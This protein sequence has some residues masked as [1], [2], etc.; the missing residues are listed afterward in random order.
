M[1]SPHK[2]A[3]EGM[4]A[5]LPESPT[6]AVIY[7]L[8]IGDRRRLCFLSHCCCTHEQADPLL[9]TVAGTF[10][11]SASF[12]NHRANPTSTTTSTRWRHEAFRRYLSLIL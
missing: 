4:A 6:A 8:D 12:T 3:A 11:V 7:D 9:A 2:A 10:E 1:A 5:G